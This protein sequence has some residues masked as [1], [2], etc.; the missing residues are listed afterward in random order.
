MSREGQTSF[1]IIFGYKGVKGEN[2]AGSAEKQ[3]QNASC[4]LLGRV[5][6]RTDMRETEICHTGET[7]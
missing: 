1:M 7:K 4:V 5:K 3:K 6:V 2:G